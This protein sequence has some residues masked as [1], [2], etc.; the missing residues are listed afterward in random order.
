MDTQKLKNFVL[1]IPREIDPRGFA[2]MNLL[3]KWYHKSFLFFLRS[4]LRVGK[5]SLSTFSWNHRTTKY[6]HWCETF[7]LFLLQSGD[8]FYGHTHPALLNGWI[9]SWYGPVLPQFSIVC[10]PSI[11]EVLQSS[12]KSNV[13]LD[14]VGLVSRVICVWLWCQ[15][16]RYWFCT[17][18]RL[19]CFVVLL[20][21]LLRWNSEKKTKG[22]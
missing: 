11:Q 21:T 19:V 1:L 9:L 20:S 7:S 3:P 6:S 17:H 4:L 2:K 12:R 13:I 15:C 5:N 16:A 14:E 8:R 22:D 10:L 18:L